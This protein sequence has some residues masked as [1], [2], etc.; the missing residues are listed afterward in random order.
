MLKIYNTL[1]KQKEEFIPLSP[2]HVGMYNCGPT[3]YHYAHIGNLRA[4][5]FADTLK[6]VLEFNN[7]KVKRVINITDVGH[8]VGDSDTGQDKT[9][10]GAKRENKTVKE[11][12]NFYTDQFLKNL[13][14]LNIETADTL[15]PKAT[16]H[17]PEQ[18]ALISNLEKK[19]FT[20]KTSD[21]IYFDSQKFKNYGKLGNIDLAQ[22]KEGARVTINSE[23]KHLT[24]FALWKFSQPHE[25]REQEW[26]SPWGIGFPGWHIEC[27][28]MS[29]KYLGETI[30]I[31][32][33]GIDHIPI[34]HNNEIAQS[35]SATGK[36]FV[37]YWMHSAFLNVPD[38]KMSKSENNFLKLEDLTSTEEQHINPLA[39]RYWLLTAHY[40]SQIIFS[41]EA[42]RAS[43][44]AFLK[45]AHTYNEVLEDD[46]ASEESK[47]S[48]EYLDKFTSFV[49]DDLDTPQAIALIWNL[50]KD[51]KVS[52]KDKKAT[53]GVFDQVLG[54]NLSSVIKEKKKK[55]PTAKVKALL[56][57]RELAR[58]SKNWPLADSLR[59]QIIQHG[60]EVLDTDKG[61]ELRGV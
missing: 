5:V 33:G 43:E 29:I 42:L 40:R 53:I 22:L 6:R 47:V 58:K 54:L 57:E 30:D 27:S 44:V 14:D 10:E 46:N 7:Y 15:F 26:E 35:E 4:Y 31:H 41:F 13:K 18:I 32:T 36:T 50:I 23:K 55:A 45:L 19:G 2:D 34:H 28:A 39:Y 25:K 12:T 49:N 16:E 52:S 9:E 61:Q 1:S 8:L 56:E 11:I 3:V 24:D 37:K 20:Y 21:G 51:K 48:T 38:G 60:F 59:E 17:I